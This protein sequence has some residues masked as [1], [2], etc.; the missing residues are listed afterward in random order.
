MVSWDPSAQCK[1]ALPGLCKSRMAGLCSW[2]GMGTVLGA[3]SRT[4]TELLR[5]RAGREGGNIL[6][7]F[8]QQ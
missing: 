8:C 6:I 3:P 1:A 5:G 2:Q 4:Q 7:G